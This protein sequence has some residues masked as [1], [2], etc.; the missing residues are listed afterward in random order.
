[1]GVNASFALIDAGYYSEKNITE[2]YANH[3]SFLTRLPSSRTLYKSLLEEHKDVESVEN[4]VIYGKRV[5]YVK[6]VPIALFGNN[7]FAYV[8]CDLKRKSSETAKYLIGAKE[9]NLSDDT[10]KEALNEKGKFIII[11]SDEISVNDVIPLYYTRQSAENL[12]GVSKSF[13]DFLPIRTHSIET[14]R[15]YLMLT[16][17]TL[18]VYIELKRRLNNVFT[19]ESALTEMANLMVKIYDRTAIV[20]EPTKNM[21]TISALLGYMVPM[22]L[23]V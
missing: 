16:F 2:L 15:G 5:L 20:L 1:M 4:I 14:L 6:R 11:S 21:K 13:L 7:G 23:G 10:I 12:F 18:I 8:V 9:D 22:N 19:V 3:I 17:I